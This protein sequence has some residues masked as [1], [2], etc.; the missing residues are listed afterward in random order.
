MSYLPW[1]P[2]NSVWEDLEYERLERLEKV[3]LDDLAYENAKCDSPHS[4]GSKCMPE[5]DGFVYVCFDR[6]SQNRNVR[7]NRIISSEVV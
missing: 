2:G 4:D 6:I 1:G 7:G 5:F 3:R